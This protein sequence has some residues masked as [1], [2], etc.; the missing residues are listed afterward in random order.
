MAASVM[1]KEF[2]DDGNSNQPS[3]RLA[4]GEHI[5]QSRRKTIG[6]ASL[7]DIDERV[8]DGRDQIGNGD[9]FGGWFAAITRGLADDL[10][11]F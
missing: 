3:N 5:E 1:R 9:G 10:A 6:D 2:M 7:A 8:H 11:H 4:S